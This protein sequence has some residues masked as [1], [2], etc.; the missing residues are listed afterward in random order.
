MA[1]PRSVLITGASSGIGEALALAYAAP[2]V[3]LALGGRDAGRL[4]AV[5]GRCAERGAAVES[6]AVD[7]GDR[8]SMAAWIAAIDQ[9]AP[10]DLVVANAGISGGP[11]SVD[12][13]EARTRAIFAVNIDGVLNTLHPAIPLMCGRGRGQLAIVSSMAGFQGLPGAPAY[14]ASKAAVRVYGEALR[15]WL[16]PRGVGLSVVCPGFV[17]SRITEGN[18]FP[19]PFLMDADRAARTI[20][21]GLA[22]NRG[23]IAFPWP[24]YALVRLGAALPPGLRDILMRR[25]PAKD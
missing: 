4:A 14:S 15:G 22:R 7:V 9:G 24:L 19:M 12:E 1:D 25:A 20:V 13:I 8:E 2:E 11:G 23:L 17:R 18:R 3:S 5:A 10:L 21:R 6:A 16:R